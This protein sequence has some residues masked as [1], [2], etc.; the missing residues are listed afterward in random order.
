[1][2]RRLLTTQLLFS[3]YPRAPQTS[4]NPSDISMGLLSWFK[5]DKTSNRVY[6]RHFEDAKGRRFSVGSGMGHRIRSRPPPSPRGSQDS[7][8]SALYRWVEAIGWKV[9]S[10]KVHGCINERRCSVLK[11]WI[12]CLSVWPNIIFLFW[13]P[14]VVSQLFWLGVVYSFPWR[15][16]SSNEI[17]WFL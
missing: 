14:W 4:F 11:E 6:E 3:D 1:M 16:V 5:G 9:C 17:A 13:S 8:K 12:G 15:S 10:G 7:G 2:D